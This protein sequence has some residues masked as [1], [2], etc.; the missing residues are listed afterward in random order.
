MSIKSFFNQDK[1]VTGIVAGLGSEVGFVLV[2]AAGLLIAG[3]PLGNHLRWFGG[4]FI[5][6]ILVLRHYAKDRSHLCVVKTL[7]V[8]FFITF[9]AFI[10]Y[11]LK[12]RIIVFQ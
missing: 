12:A 5:P 3:E 6:L 2:L 4:M 7:I 11:M 10:A 1:V 9:L 8:L